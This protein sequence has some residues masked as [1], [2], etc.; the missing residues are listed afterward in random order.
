MNKIKVYLN[1]NLFSKNPELKPK[2]VHRGLEGLPEIE[3]GEEAEI[4]HLV[5]FEEYNLKNVLE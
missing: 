3:D 5:F 1:Y 2:I 4:D